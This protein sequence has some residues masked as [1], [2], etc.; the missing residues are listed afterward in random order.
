MDGNLWTG[1][2]LIPGDPHN[3]N[4]NGKLFQNF[5][6]RN[7]HLFVVN[8]LDVCKGLITRYRKTTKWEEKYVIDL[9]V[10]CYKVCAFLLK[11]VVDEQFG[12]SNFNPVKIGQRVKDSDHN[13]LI[14]ELNMKYF[15]ARSERVELFNFKNTECQE[16]FTNLTNQTKKLIECFS[17]ENSFQSQSKAWF[18]TLGSCFQQSFK[19]IRVT[20]GRV[21]DNPIP[22]M[23]RN[24]KEIKLKMKNGEEDLEEVLEKLEKEN[25]RASEDKN[26]E[27]IMN[28]FKSLAQNQ[29][30]VNMWNLKKKFFP[31]VAQ[32]KPTGKK[33]IDG[34]II[35]SP[36]GLK[37]L[38]LD[39]F[40]HRLRHRPIREDFNPIRLGI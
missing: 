17:N 9:F 21:K 19:K 27:V 7:P 24:R 30:S 8:S 38:Y 32:S 18:K 6:D 37:M 3:Q 26:K 2:H 12:L 23:L 39:T 10:I 22:Q 31:K 35:T 29:D 5:L 34:Q 33:N 13:P 14:M 40:I 28:N 15:E 1:P 20:E 11:M 16:V 25:G 36:D 4:Q